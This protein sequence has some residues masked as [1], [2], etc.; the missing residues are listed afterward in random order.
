MIPTG[1]LSPAA[2]EK[3]KKHAEKRDERLKLMVEEYR[4]GKFDEFIKT[5]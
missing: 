3:L 1:E 2:K 5:L 4:S